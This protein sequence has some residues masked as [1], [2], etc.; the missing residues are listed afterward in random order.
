MTTTTETITQ[1]NYYQQLTCPVQRTSIISLHNR[2]QIAHGLEVVK[3]IS[4]K[5]WVNIHKPSGGAKAVVG[6]LRN[7]K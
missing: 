4:F 2:K 5:Q 3:Y 6:E 1:T 7:N